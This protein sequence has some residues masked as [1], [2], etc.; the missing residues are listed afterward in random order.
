[1]KSIGL[2]AL[3]ALAQGLLAQSP[4]K[5]TFAY[6]RDTAS[7]PNNNSTTSAQPAGAKTDYL[8]YVVVAKGTIVSAS[9][10]CVLGK[11]F[12]ATLQKV[13]SPV[14]VEHDPAKPT[15]A[16]DTLVKTTSDDVYRVELGESQTKQCLPADEGGPPQGS[17]I[18]VALRSG[19]GQ[20]SWNAVADRIVPLHPNPTAGAGS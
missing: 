9:S 18:A 14:M 19:S 16:K 20:N 13:D 8:I 3:F 15:G 5:E 1:M 6:S 10:A 2:L 11:A 12:A 17:A 7:V 4:V